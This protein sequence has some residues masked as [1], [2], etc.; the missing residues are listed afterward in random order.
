VQTPLLSKEG[1]GEVGWWDLSVQLVI[2]ISH[3]E[4]TGQ[5]I[6]E[7]LTLSVIISYA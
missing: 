6:D 7:N 2:Y 3:K 4:F 5:D 1:P